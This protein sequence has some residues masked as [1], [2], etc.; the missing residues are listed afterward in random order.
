MQMNQPAIIIGG[1][2]LTGKT[3]LAEQLQS[4]GLGVSDFV[5]GDELHTQESL[6]KMRFGTPLSENDRAEWKQRIRDNISNRP[7]ESFRIISCSALSRA[8]RD[9]LRSAGDVRFL[10]LVFVRESAERRALKRL[11]DTWVQLHGEPSKQ[12][13]YFQPRIYP[14]LLDAQYR[15]LQIPD[16]NETDCFVIDLDK[17]PA[18]EYGPVPD[19]AN[20]VPNIISWLNTAS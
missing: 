8:F 14:Q 20:L 6:E 19:F 7:T 1:I 3:T 2:C 5:E 4:S 11:R 18:G 15:D 16:R 13:H 12:P 9:D 17:Y 10:F